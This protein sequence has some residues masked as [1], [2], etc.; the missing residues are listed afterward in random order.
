MALKGIKNK[1]A[2]NNIKNSLARRK[3]AS[4]LFDFFLFR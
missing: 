3:E 1:L 4:I 2:L